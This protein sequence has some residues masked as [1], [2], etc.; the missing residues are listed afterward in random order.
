MQCSQHPL[1]T[2]KHGRQ[3][4]YTYIYIYIYIYIRH[5][6]HAR[7]RDGSYPCPT[8]PAPG[9]VF[10]FKGPPTPNTAAARVTN[11]RSFFGHLFAMPFWSILA[12][13]WPQLASQLGS[14]IDQ[15]SIQEPSKLHPNLHL[16][17]DRLSDGFSNEFSSIFDSQI[18]QK[19]I[20]I[21]SKS[22]PNITTTKK[23]KS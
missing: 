20:K 14:K 11:L 15:K 2:T 12:P 17:F 9:P 18:D 4:L 16:V 21:Q 7:E 13:T 1:I 23:Q 8:A 5:R 19:S 10:S 6:A 3:P 22:Q